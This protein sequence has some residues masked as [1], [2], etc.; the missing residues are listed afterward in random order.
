L[1]ALN[2]PDCRGPGEGIQPVS[3]RLLRF[4]DLAASEGLEGQFRGEQ[5]FVVVVSDVHAEASCGTVRKQVSGYFRQ[6]PRRSFLGG[7]EI[8][9]LDAFVVADALPIITAIKVI[10]RHEFLIPEWVGT[11]LNP[12]YVSLL[13]DPSAH[14]RSTSNAGV[15]AGVGGNRTFLRPRGM[16]PDTTRTADMLHN[17]ADPGSLEDSRRSDHFHIRQ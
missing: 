8:G 9:Q 17:P 11:F 3:S 4:A 2:A 10:A 14:N 15:M 7:V 1:Q 12:G 5:Y 13:T 16:H 6:R